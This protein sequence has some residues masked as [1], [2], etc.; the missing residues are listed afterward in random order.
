[1]FAQVKEDYPRASER[2]P[3]R[4]FS[5]SRSRYCERPADQQRAHVKNVGLR[6]TI[7]RLVLEL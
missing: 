6:D 1:M 2:T 7:E 5:V 3:C 4:L